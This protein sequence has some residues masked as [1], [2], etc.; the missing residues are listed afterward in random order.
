MTPIENI[1]SNP[2]Y[3]TNLIKN[4][5]C[6]HEEKDDFIILYNY[7]CSKIQLK[8]HIILDDELAWLIGFYL[9]EGTKSR[10][11]IA[12][13]N[14][15]LPLIK[16]SLFI[17]KNKLGVPFD[18]WKIAIK[19]SKDVSL[20]KCYWQSLFENNK[21]YISYNAL[22]NKDNLDI[23]INNRIFVKIFNNILQKFLPLI[24]DNKLLSIALLKG[25]LA[26]DG[27]I[28]IR[29]GCLHNIGTV[30]DDRYKSILVKAF[31]TFIGKKPLI[32][33]TKNVYELY[34]C[35]VEI[36]V[37]FVMNEFFFDME[38][39]SN[40][41]LNSF[42]RK[43]Y[44]R[45]HFK[46][47]NAIKNQQLSAVEIAQL[48]NNSHWSVRDAMNRDIKVGLVAYSKFKAKKER[49]PKKKYFYLTQNGKR[50]LYVLNKH[51]KERGEI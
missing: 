32:R 11:T 28:N 34:F 14:C 20:R 47:W 29:K 8:K 35:H 10:N 51:I 12:F 3:L 49:G 2:I 31:E 26:G 15:E 4:I 39:Q 27:S 48:T 25:H 46:Y 6:K 50:L 21:L 43:Q 13:S 9:A 24:L 37:F 44:V 22:A 1:N 41:L 5:N 19:T 33:K 36:L 42:L 7:Q 45:S 40:K 38:R 17:A 18:I 16:K 23:R 30:V